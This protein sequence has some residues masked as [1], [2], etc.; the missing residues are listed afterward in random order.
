[1]IED[2][3]VKIRRMLS[4]T[5]TCSS[6]HIQLIQKGERT[7]CLHLSLKISLKFCISVYS[8]TPLPCTLLNFI[9]TDVVNSDSCYNFL[10]TVCADT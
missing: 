4:H 1:M 7:T 2:V 9:E 8:L 3:A 6:R 10:L 5:N